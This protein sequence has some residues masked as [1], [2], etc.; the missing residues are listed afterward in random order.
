MVLKVLETLALGVHLPKRMVDFVEPLLKQF[1]RRI[2]GSR[3]HL[4]FA[5]E[6]SRCAAMR[7]AGGAPSG[8]MRRHITS[9]RAAPSEPVTITGWLISGRASPQTCSISKNRGEL[10]AGRVADVHV[11]QKVEQS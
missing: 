8:T 7:S 10:I 9:A 3:F 2:I 4:L 5:V 11:F 1:P 6:L